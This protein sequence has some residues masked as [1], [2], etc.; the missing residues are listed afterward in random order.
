MY[1]LI[2]V[3][4]DSLRHVTPFTLTI[5]SEGDRSMHTTPCLN[6]DTAV[7]I[8]THDG[9]LHPSKAQ[10]PANPSLHAIARLLGRQA[11]MHVRKYRF[12]G[13]GRIQIVIREIGISD[14]L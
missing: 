12:E 7:E 2:D 6:Y 1:T 14:D 8:I 4:C 13:L 5:W 3:T 10:T 9:S 11:A